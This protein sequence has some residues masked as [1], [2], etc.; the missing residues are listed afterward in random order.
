MTGPLNESVRRRWMQRTAK[1]MGEGEAK[2]AL[3]ES[4]LGRENGHCTVE[5]SVGKRGSIS[6]CRGLFLFLTQNHR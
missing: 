5:I 4:R 3:A 2:V 1:K 6:V